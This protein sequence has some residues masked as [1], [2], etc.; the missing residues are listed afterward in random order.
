MRG[1]EG[2]GRPAVPE[3]AVCPVGGEGD[4]VGQFPSRRSV[5][6]AEEGY[7]MAWVKRIDWNAFIEA[8]GHLKFYICRLGGGLAWRAGGRADGGVGWRARGY[9]HM[10]CC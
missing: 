4:G 5:R 6:W 2:G 8:L 1:L 9:H 10:A 3:Q 7:H